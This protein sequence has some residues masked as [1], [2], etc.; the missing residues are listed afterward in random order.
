MK[1]KYFLS[2]VDDEHAYC[3]SPVFIV[4]SITSP[5]SLTL[6]QYVLF[7]VS[8]AC[9]PITFTVPLTQISQRAKADTS[10]PASAD[11]NAFSPFECFLSRTIFSACFVLTIAHHDCEC[12]GRT[13]VVDRGLISVSWFLFFIKKMI[14]VRLWVCVYVSPSV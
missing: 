3:Y 9:D 14:E 7:S 6:A 4:S 5:P 10:T 2:F 11:T 12:H 8:F 13:S 1:S